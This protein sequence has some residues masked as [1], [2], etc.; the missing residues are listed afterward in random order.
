MHGVIHQSTCLQSRRYDLCG[1]A[2]LIARSVKTVAMFL[3]LTLNSRLRSR[4]VLSL[5]G[6]SSSK[7]P[8]SKSRATRREHGLN[9]GIVHQ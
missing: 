9:V 1:C 8:V 4:P 7:F 5:T 3:G 6:P 2:S